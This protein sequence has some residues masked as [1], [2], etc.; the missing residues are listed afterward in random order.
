[1]IHIVPK[2]YQARLVIPNLPFRATFL[3]SVSFLN[4]AKSVDKQNAFET[5]LFDK[6]MC[7]PSVCVLTAWFG[8]PV[9]NIYILTGGMHKAFTSPQGLRSGALL[10]LT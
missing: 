3:A 8:L 1:M 9:L 5:R 6:C 10:N 4:E 7:V 2:V